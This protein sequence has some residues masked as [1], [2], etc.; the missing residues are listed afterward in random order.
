MGANADAVP[1][2]RRIHRRGWGRRCRERLRLAD[3]RA[4]PTPIDGDAGRVS[5]LDV[6]GTRPSRRRS[7]DPNRPGG[8]SMGESSKD[9]RHDVARFAV[10]RV[11]IPTTRVRLD[12]GDA[13]IPRS[14]EAAEASLSQEIRAADETVIR[15]WRAHASL[16]RVWP[17][18]RSDRHMP[19]RDDAGS[20]CTSRYPSVIYAST[21]SC[22]R[23]SSSLT[24]PYSAL[25]PFGCFRL[26]RPR[27]T[28]QGGTW[29]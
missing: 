6:L 19:I 29:L 7:W 3:G 23:F 1:T 4:A 13:E 27:R 5:A 16:H 25:P 10:W 15:P 9:P 22:G 8:H 28:W 20:V 18:F 21:S 24:L 14:T 17:P 26:G 11:R 2:V 12:A